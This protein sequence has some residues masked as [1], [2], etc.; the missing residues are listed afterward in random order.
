MA[1]ETDVWHPNVRA[2]NTLMA[3]IVED[4]NPQRLKMVTRI[5]IQVD[6]HLSSPVLFA[7]S[8]NLSREPVPFWTKQN[9]DA[10]QASICP[11]DQIRPIINKDI[12]V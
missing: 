1:T 2:C 5:L 11:E 6:R 10:G 12:P 7:A 9:A 3:Q 8:L 4:R